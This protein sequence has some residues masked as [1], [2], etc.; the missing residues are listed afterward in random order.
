MAAGSPQVEAD[1]PAMKSTEQRI[2]NTGHLPSAG[3]FQRRQTRSEGKADRL[4]MAVPDQVRSR[5]RGDSRC[6]ASSRLKHKK[7]T[8][9]Q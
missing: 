2:E 6:S 9:V 8:P 5:E 4:R 7:I 3:A 1:N